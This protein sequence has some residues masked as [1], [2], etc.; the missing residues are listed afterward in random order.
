M[1]LKFVQVEL[2]CKISLVLL[3]THFNQLVSTPAARPMLTG[4]KEILYPEVKVFGLFSICT[5][6]LCFS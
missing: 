3:Q 4:L 2:V 6:N 5:W 1:F